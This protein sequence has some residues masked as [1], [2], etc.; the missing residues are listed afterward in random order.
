MAS[1]QMI[2]EEIWFHR[3]QMLTANV[4]RCILAFACLRTEPRWPNLFTHVNRKRGCAMNQLRIFCFVPCIHGNHHSTPSARLNFCGRVVFSVQ[5][6]HSKQH[7]TPIVKLKFLGR[8]VFSVGNHQDF[9]SHNGE[10]LTQSLEI[11]NT[12]RKFAMLVPN[13]C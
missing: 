1:S 13:C 7:S 5:K 10:N 2:D 4:T 12:E 6:H 8:V 9:H 11:L 3:M